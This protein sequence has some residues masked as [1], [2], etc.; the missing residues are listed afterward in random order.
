[1][2]WSRLWSGHKIIINSG[3][4]SHTPCFSLDSASGSYILL[5][6]LAEE[7]VEG[8][9]GEG[10]VNRVEVVDRVTWDTQQAEPKIPS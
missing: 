10:D 2:C 1:M 5:Y 3:I 7:G 9:G 6:S 4:G 8:G